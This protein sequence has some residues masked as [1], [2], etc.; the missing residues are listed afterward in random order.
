M[1]FKQ[2]SKRVVTA[3]VV[4]AGAG[5]PSTAIARPIEAGSTFSVSPPAVTAS[6]PQPAAQAAQGFEWGDAGVGAA[7]MLL[8]IG[9]G[10]GAVVAVRRRGGRAVMG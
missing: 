7:G 3:S 6:A 9:V 4:I 2:I 8:V 1:L 5:L 10:S